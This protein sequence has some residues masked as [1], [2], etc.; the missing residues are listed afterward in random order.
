MIYGAASAGLGANCAGIGAAIPIGCHA[1]G[2]GMASAA[3]LTAD[4]T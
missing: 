3:A 4:G 2:D 1:I